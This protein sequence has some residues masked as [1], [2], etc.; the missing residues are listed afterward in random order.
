[1]VARRGVG[2]GDAAIGGVSGA[3][4]ADGRAVDSVIAGDEA[5][6]RAVERVGLGDGLRGEQGEGERQK[7]SACALHG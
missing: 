6:P 7:G 1:M 2:H 5:D 4:D 3:G